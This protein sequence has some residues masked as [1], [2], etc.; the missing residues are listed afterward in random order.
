MNIVYTDLIKKSPFWS[1]SV[2]GVIKVI[3]KAVFV[4]R[5]A[6]TFRYIEAETDDWFG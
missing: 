6:V 1:V 2:K 5:K 4:Q 3:T